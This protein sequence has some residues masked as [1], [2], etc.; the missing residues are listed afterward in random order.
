MKYLMKSNNDHLALGGSKSPESVEPVVTWAM[1]CIWG[2]AS[3]VAAVPCNAFLKFP[4]RPER[5]RISA[6][7]KRCKSDV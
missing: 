2:E 6:D 3:K 1:V 7:F 4:V 5:E